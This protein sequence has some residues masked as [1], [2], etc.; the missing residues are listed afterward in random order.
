MSGE[1]GRRS[2]LKEDRCNE[3]GGT[4]GKE[5][6]CQGYETAIV[7]RFVDG[8]RP[9]DV[10]EITVNA[11]APEGTTTSHQ[12]FAVYHDPT[13]KYYTGQYVLFPSRSMASDNH[14]G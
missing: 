4:A 6:F 10:G 12:T 11:T 5:Q 2:I 9:V 7:L 3:I 13:M 8:D 14:A 1:C